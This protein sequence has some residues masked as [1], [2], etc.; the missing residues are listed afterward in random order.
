MKQL[1]YKL[2]LIITTVFVFPLDAISGSMWGEQ[3]YDECDCC[4]MMVDHLR[5]TATN[6]IR[7]D[8]ILSALSSMVDWYSWHGETQEL[9]RSVYEAAGQRIAHAYLLTSNGGKLTSPEICDYASY[10]NWSHSPGGCSGCSVY[11]GT[12]N[13][14]WQ[15]TG[16][17][18]YQQSYVCE[19][20]CNDCFETSAT[21]YRCAAGYYGTSSNGT[22]GC[23]KCTSPGTST[24]GSTSITRC[25]VPSGTTGSDST[26][27][28]TYTSNC[29]W[30]N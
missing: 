3:C 29:Y 1:P 20:I 5:D 10:G 16:V 30:S 22:S 25:Y 12:S 14:G 6:Y 21:S 17:P 28:F 8:E 19:N 4:V 9:M 7:E 13:S 18:G 23:T 15:S 24:A 27:T 2:F 26:G 11:D